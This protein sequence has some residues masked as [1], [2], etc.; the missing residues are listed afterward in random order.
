MVSNF[1]RNLS[2]KGKPM[3]LY[4]TPVSPY[5]RK[6]QAYLAER[7]M[8]AEVVGVGIGDPNPDFAKANPLKK[9]PA[10]Q[11]GDFGIGDSSAIITYLEGKYPGSTLIPNDAEGKAAVHWFDKF[12]DTVL[13]PSGGKIFF[14]RIVMPKFM[15]AEGNEAMASEGEAELP[16]HYAYLDGA[17]SDA[18]YLVGDRF[19]L[20]DISV[21]CLLGNLRLIG[22]G[23]DAATYPKLSAW[24]EA[25]YARPCISASFAHAEKIFAKIA[26]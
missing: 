7:G 25:C 10:L 17:I 18:G 3:I 15:G 22:L 4:G 21:A 5:V 6:V 1:H 26:G 13:G 9:M 19:T 12:A 11:D 16:K 14:N 2:R 20:A 23:P 8:E 24:L